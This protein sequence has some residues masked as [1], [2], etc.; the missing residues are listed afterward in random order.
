MYD[1]MMHGGLQASGKLRSS[2][3]AFAM[4]PPMIRKVAHG[5]CT[6]ETHKSVARVSA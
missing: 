3:T 4:A 6:V 1:A 5:I 2:G